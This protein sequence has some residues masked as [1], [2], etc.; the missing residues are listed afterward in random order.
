L[1]PTPELFARC[2]PSRRRPDA[3]AAPVPAM[4]AALPVHRAS[5][6]DAAACQGDR[7]SLR[8]RAR[9]RRVAGLPGDELDQGSRPDPL[10]R[11]LTGPLRART[12]EVTRRQGGLI[13]HL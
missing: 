5:L 6:A 1:C 2:L 9:D 11:T 13:S 7:N 10:R 4:A 3:A 8:H 12:P